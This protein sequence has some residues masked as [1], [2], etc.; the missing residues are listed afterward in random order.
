MMT[1]IEVTT[2]QKSIALQL[3]AIESDRDRD[4]IRVAKEHLRQMEPYLRRLKRLRDRRAQ[5][6]EMIAE[7][8]G[9]IERLRREL[10]LV[11]QS[12]RIEKL[13][14][15]V[16]KINKL[17]RGPKSQLLM[18]KL[19]LGTNRAVDFLFLIS[20]YE[21]EIR[22]LERLRDDE[23]FFVKEEKKLLV[24]I[25]AEERR[26]DTFVENRLA[27]DMLLEKLLAR[28]SDLCV[29][30][31]DMRG[32]QTLRKY[33]EFKQK[34]L[35]ATMGLTEEQVQYIIDTAGKETV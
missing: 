13:R 21:M 27:H 12:A 23:A 5:A 19:R 6:N 14:R 34:W 20:G 31:R 11:A 4:P 3:R 2:E 33:E 18:S 28:Q 35:A 29:V 1:L 32:N 25:E 9:R 15:L 7:Y 8:L 30:E 16:D 17:R 22:A 24:A 10:K 26:W